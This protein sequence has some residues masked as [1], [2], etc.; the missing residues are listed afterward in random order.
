MTICDLIP[1]KDSN[2]EV[3]KNILYYRKYVLIP[4]ANFIQDRL[5]ISLDKRCMNPVIKI[6]RHCEKLNIDFLFCDRNQIFEKNIYN[7]NIE[8]ILETSLRC[9]DNDKFFD[10]INDGKID[11][12]GKLIR[13]IQEYDC[14]N[15]FSKVYYETNKYHFQRTWFDYFQNRLHYHVKRQDIRDYFNALEREVSILLILS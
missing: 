9:L 1:N 7:E 5:F 14:M 10:L 3:K 8:I 12:L 11:Y 6:I 2:W 4:V 13:F 15:S